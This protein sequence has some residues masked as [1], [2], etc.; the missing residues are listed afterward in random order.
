MKLISLYFRCAVLNRFFKNSVFSCK[1]FFMYFFFLIINSKGRSVI[2]F[3][4]MKFYFLFLIKTEIRIKI[5]ISEMNAIRSVNV[6]KIKKKR[7]QKL[8]HLQ[9][10][11]R[12]IQKYTE[13]NVNV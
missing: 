12:D 11:M 8:F 7:Y 9:L 2:N 5:V 4:N 13:N 3:V 1:F 10:I 6:L